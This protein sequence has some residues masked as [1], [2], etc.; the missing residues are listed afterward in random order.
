MQLS[1]EDL[2]FSSY[3]AYASIQ[4]VHTPIDRPPV[5]TYVTHNNRRHGI[6]YLPYAASDADR[7]HA[8]AR[9]I[10][11]HV[12]GR[13]LLPPSLLA[14]TFAQPGRHTLDLIADHL[15]ASRQWIEARIPAFTPNDELLHEAAQLLCAPVASI[16]TVLSPHPSVAAA[17]V[18]AFLLATIGTAWFPPLPA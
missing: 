10:A 2:R 11:P 13:L 3:L 1:P 8:T 18:Q 12:L 5:L 16:R 4:I 9:C 15:I 14:P 17:H 6:L 7:H